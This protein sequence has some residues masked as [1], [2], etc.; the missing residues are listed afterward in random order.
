MIALNCSFHGSVAIGRP[1]IL[2]GDLKLG[3]KPGKLPLQFPDDACR[4]GLSVNVGP[5][6]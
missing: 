6:K 2:S 5:L 3:P 1:R 4:L